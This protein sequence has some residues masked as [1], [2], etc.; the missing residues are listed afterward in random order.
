MS[1][2]IFEHAQNFSPNETDINGRRRTRNGLTGRESNYKRMRTDL[3]FYCPFNVRWCYPVMCEQGI[4]YLL[5]DSLQKWNYTQS[6]EFGP[7]RTVSIKSSLLCNGDK[8]FQDRIPHGDILLHFKQFFLIKRT[9][10]RWQ[11]NNSQSDF[12]L[13]LKH[14][15][16]FLT[17]WWY[18]RLVCHYYCILFICRKIQFV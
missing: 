6:K 3:I 17:N 8:Y 4:T 15:S 1:V 7:W 2:P 10:L 9:S 11:A 5:F 12:L 13:Y 14:I 16:S 18:F